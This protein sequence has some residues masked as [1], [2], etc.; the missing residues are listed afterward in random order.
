MPR[1]RR[2][3]RKRRELDEQVLDDEF[4]ET[5]RKKNLR[6]P[7]ILFIGL[8][9]IAAL[10]FFL[11]TIIAV[12]PL[13]QIAVDTALSKLNGKLDLK[14]VSLGWFSPVELTGV[15]A[16]DDLGKPLFFAEKISTEK[17]L[18]ALITGSD[19]GRVAVTEPTVFLK[20]RED[21]S[22]IEDAFANYLNADTQDSPGP[23]VEIAIS[24]GNVAL[25]VDDQPPRWSFQ[26]I[27]GKLKANQPK[28]PLAAKFS[29]AVISQ[30]PL[31]SQ[32]QA[33]GQFHIEVKIDEGT[34]QLAFKRGAVSL[35]ARQ[36]PTDAATPFLTRFYERMEMGGL[37]NGEIA[38][39]WSDYG[40]SISLNA[41]PANI[42][43]VR[44][45]A[46]N[47]IGDD[48]IRLANLKVMGELSLTPEMVDAT[49]FV[50]ETD[51]G[52]LRANGGFAWRQL[53]SL[54]NNFEIPAT[55]FQS[56]AELD[57][58]KL[59]GMLPNTLP[60]QDDLTI[61]SGS[62]QFTASSRVEG[63]IRKLVFNGESA[64]LSAIR[65]GQ[66]INWHKPIRLVAVL[67]QTPESVVVESLDCSSN[68]LKITGSATK[69]QG[70]FT[71]TGDL[72]MAMQE[73]GR[74][75]HLGGLDLAGKID[76][77]FA[78]KFDAESRLADRPFRTG[79]KFRI[80]QPAINWPGK[81]NW[82][83]PELNIVVQAAGQ[84]VGN[85][86]KGQG[87]Q[88]D[89]GN[90]L[91]TAGSERLSAKL[92]TPIATTSTAPTKLQCELSGDVANWLAQIRTIV[93]IDAV[94][95]GKI[96]AHGI[97]VIHPNQLIQVEKSNY[98]FENLEFVGY[99]LNVSEP[100][101]MGEAS[102]GYEPDTG[103][104][105][106][107]NV[108][109]A[110]S[111][112]SALGQKLVFVPATGQGTLQGDIAFRADVNRLVSWFAGVPTEDSI[113]WFGDAEGT[114]AFSTEDDT[115][116]GNVSVLVHN[117]V[118]AQPQKRG[119]AVVQNVSNR[120]A[121]TTLL[122]DERVLLETKL[123]LDRSMN[124][125]VFRNLDVD[126][127]SA[128]IH[129][130]G[131]ISEWDSTMMADVEGRWRPN[132]QSLKPLM[133]SFTGGVVSL[134]GVTAQG[135]EIKGPIFNG[136]S[137]GPNVAWLNPKLQVTTALNWQSGSILGMPVG[138]SSVAVNLNQGIARI[139][140]GSIP[141]SGG[142]INLNPRLNLNGAS[143]VLEMPPGRVMDQV[144]LSPEICRGWLKMV[145]PILAD[146]T[147][148]QGR[149]SVTTTELRVPIENIEQADFGGAIQLHG[150]SVG[151]GPL[152]QQ[153]V[154]L[155]SQVKSL[156]AGSPLGAALTADSTNQK[157][158]IVMPEQTVPY[159]VKQGRVFH[160]GLKFQVDDVT[161]E[162][163]GSVGLDQ[164]M[165]LI[166]TV[167]IH[168]KWVGNEKW[169]AGL[170]GQTLQIPINGTVS[171]PRIDSS[172]LQQISQQLVGQ[173]ATGALQNE[174]NGLIQQGS[175]KLENELLK[176]LNK[177]LVPKK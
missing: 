124:S 144:Q 41:A 68:F 2:R 17:T 37:L 55:D 26:Q 101:I 139:D 58:A 99:G 46:P 128:K 158:W 90:L 156:A 120:S 134:D 109:V 59:A 164:S 12:T 112:L 149:F 153:L 170:R 23:P 27:T 118:A 172:S 24:N 73:L 176:G 143:P 86:T 66:P 13:R 95:S 111:A 110:S 81:T 70:E 42:Q 79:G 125:I 142:V 36:L 141:F 89:T 162:T 167:P 54:K 18:L 148:A 49:D 102:F 67:R 130:D 63:E 77:H 104:F 132:W 103:L 126:A 82:S 152:G 96:D 115:I 135:F 25:S 157:A 74:F 29:G 150:A 87:L 173:A 4:V 5:Q 165:S 9:T 119:Q 22:N 100:R 28:L 48:Q 138:S 45:M 44:F 106:V 127:S 16:A 53:A 14:A 174:V 129:A 145:A 147:S 75:V 57:L 85:Q 72:S 177:I 114:V 33:A 3:T 136:A 38:A 116:G 163:K 121:W 159:A 84:W 51:I 64:G 107:P 20:L 171:S 166:A 1:S 160:N 43:H 8:V 65:N 19:F 108:T 47:R 117:L 39:K 175:K 11:P 151:P 161:I 97:A 80:E 105:R 131:E 7:R 71:A 154:A 88:L 91:L 133:E 169:L 35:S 113:Q 155:V 76:G 122:K 50:C 123:V 60:L 34:Q 32:G 56:D 21:G 61:Q 98:E 94:A 83:Q 40:N 62:I 15:S 93:P 168:E 10:I 140:A 137:S 31:T 69:Q 52:H 146:V 92:L 78:W 6:V 30:D